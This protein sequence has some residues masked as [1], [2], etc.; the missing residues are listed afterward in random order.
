MCDAPDPPDIKVPEPQVLKNPF[1]DDARGDSLAISALRTGRS[2]LRIPLDTGLGIGFGARGAGTSRP[3]T[4]GP[5]GNAR[6][7][8][9]GLGIRRTSTNPNRQPTGVIP[10]AIPGGGGLNFR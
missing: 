2:A 1:L 7:P 5:A 6:N 8:S 10:D 4:A 3:G 9:R